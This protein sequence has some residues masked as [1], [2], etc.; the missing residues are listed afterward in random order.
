[1]PHVVISGSKKWNVLDQLPIWL[2]ELVALTLQYQVF[3]VSNALF[4]SYVMLVMSNP[5]SVQLVDIN[6]LEESKSTD[7]SIS[8]DHPPT[9]TLD[10][11]KFQDN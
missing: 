3:P 10:V 7:V 1:M 8:I 4:R 11:V 2:V 9:V 6:K 5:V